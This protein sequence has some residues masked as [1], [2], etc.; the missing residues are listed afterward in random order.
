MTATA[1]L[2]M[3]L[4]VFTDCSDASAVV[5]AIRSREIDAAIYESVNDPR[6]IGIVFATRDADDLLDRVGNLL[7]ADPFRQLTP[8]PSF[9]MLGRSYLVGYERD[10]EDALVHRPRGR[11][12]APDLRWAVW[13][14]LR[15]A[16]A[17]ERIAPE[18]QQRAL[19]EHG[20]VGAEF[21]AGGKA[22]DIRLA[23][24]GLDA[25]DN[26]FV[27]G[28]LGPELAPLSVLVERMRKT[29]QTSTYLE[30]LGPFFVGRVLWQSPL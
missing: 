4:H 12:L 9:T 18:E 16:G 30:K 28:I 25:S 5:E 1:S 27:I 3:Q 20:A 15:R 10:T 6:G 8:Q 2:F 13:Y 26:D 21:A 29:V 19:R 24:H 17:F 22:H 11:M 7:R 23:C 14:P